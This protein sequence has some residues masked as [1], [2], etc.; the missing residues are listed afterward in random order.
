M[1][2]LWIDYF[3]DRDLSNIESYI[4]NYTAT[5]V[6]DTNYLEKINP[7]T[8]KLESFI[9]YYLSGRD[10]RHLNI[11]PVKK[12]DE[13]HMKYFYKLWA[14]KKGINYN[15]PLINNKTYYEKPTV[16]LNNI[17]DRRVYIEQLKNIKEN[18]DLNN[19]LQNTSISYLEQT[20]DY[21]F[22]PPKSKVEAIKT[23]E[24]DFN[25]YKVDGLFFYIGTKFNKIGPNQI[26]YISNNKFI[27]FINQFDTNFYISNFFD[28]DIYIREKSC[29]NTNLRKKKNRTNILEED[30]LESRN[31]INPDITTVFN[32]IPKSDLYN[33]KYNNKYI[34]GNDLNPSID[35]LEY[36][37][38]LNE[39][40]GYEI[41]TSTPPNK[42]TYQ[43]SY[44]CFRENETNFYKT[45][46]IN[47]P[48]R[49]NPRIENF[50][51]NLLIS[52]NRY[53]RYSNLG[54]KHFKKL[55]KIIKNDYRLINNNNDE[56]YLLPLYS[57]VYNLNVPPMPY[58]Q[59]FMNDIISQIIGKSGPFGMV[60]LDLKEQQFKYIDNLQQIINFEIKIDKNK[61]FIYDYLNLYNVYVVEKNR[62]NIPINDSHK[63]PFNTGYNIGDTGSNRSGNNDFRWELK[64]FNFP[65][66]MG[67]PRD[68]TG[69]LIP[70]T[71]PANLKFNNPLDYKSFEYNNNIETNNDISITMVGVYFGTNIDRV[72]NQYNGTDNLIN[73]PIRLPPVIPCYFE[74]NRGGICTNIGKNENNYNR[75]IILAPV[76]KYVNSSNNITFNFI[77]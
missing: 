22:D 58:K 21:I 4:E 69:N 50:Y 33:I 24:L 35:K 59:F 39:V 67:N 51:Q 13:N 46:E 61:Q 41:D 5:Y 29:I 55:Q 49:V 45:D 23:V 8:T 77:F 52:Y 73:A 76:F 19:A 7:Y 2:T 31:N 1:E 20:K 36:S 40:D 11:K 70:H 32:N 44:L 43:K 10:N 28:S 47:K 63:N 65:A 18:L 25:D 66:V 30:Y 37:K 26:V 57:L 9:D 68:R 3:S 17:Q 75:N 54:K 71:H 12:L 16:N 48:L 64:R 27:K 60:L 72:I 56:L 6:E 38:H 14:K 53:N 42:K 34:S 15:E 62:Y 74:L